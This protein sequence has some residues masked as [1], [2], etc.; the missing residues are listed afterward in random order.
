MMGNKPK[1]E[2][3]ACIACDKVYTGGLGC[4]E[5]GEPG[6]PVAPPECIYCGSDELRFDPATNAVLRCER[7]SL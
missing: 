5:C 7:C 6:E 2:L 3:R 1:G 4:P